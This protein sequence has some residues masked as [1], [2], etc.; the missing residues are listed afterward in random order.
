MD[1]T[2]QFISLNSQINQNLPYNKGKSFDVNVV[3]E[4]KKE[5]YEQEENK[6]RILKYTKYLKECSDEEKSKLIQNSYN[7][8][9]HIVDKHI[10]MKQRNRN[11]EIKESSDKEYHFLEML[12][13][14]KYDNLPIKEK[15][16]KAKNK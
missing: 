5:L 16:R 15:N 14:G 8:I 4:V 1:Y 13:T 9:S 10:D 2:K 6:K 7:A 12:L 11:I 3:D